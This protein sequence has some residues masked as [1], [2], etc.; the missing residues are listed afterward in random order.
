MRRGSKKAAAL[1]LA[2]DERL[3]ISQKKQQ[4]GCEASVPRKLLAT[5]CARSE[6]SMVPISHSS[7][8]NNLTWQASNVCWLAAGP[9]WVRWVLFLPPFF[10]QVHQLAR[11]WFGKSSE[12]H[13]PLIIMIEAHAAYGWI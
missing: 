7:I 11:L 12:S 4:A 13:V 6:Q 5:A 10:M 9:L 2:V 3:L 1:H 8:Q